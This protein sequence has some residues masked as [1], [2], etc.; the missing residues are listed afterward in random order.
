MDSNKTCTAIFESQPTAIL[1]PKG[2]IP[3]WFGLKPN[4]PNPFNPTT[5]IKYQ[6]PRTTHV[7][8]RIYNLMGQEVKTLVDEV[9]QLGVHKTEWDGLDH[10]N[11]AV[12]TGF[13]V[14]RMI[15][16]DFVES[17]KVL[18]LK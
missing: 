9:K 10:Q 8:L 16:G 17:K 14:V 13:Y 11:Q 3:S 7:T 1:D 5:T 6:L 15:A 4:Y 18:L 12:S 2:E